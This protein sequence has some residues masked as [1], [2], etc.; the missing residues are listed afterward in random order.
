MN[1]VA[2]VWMGPGKHFVHYYVRAGTLVNCVCVVE[3][4]GWEVESWTQ[5]GDRDE[6]ANDFAGWHET[7][8]G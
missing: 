2:T 5:R 7:V 1:P 6:L 8:R 3:K 4:G